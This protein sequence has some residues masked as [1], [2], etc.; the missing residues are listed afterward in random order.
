M[1]TV[2]LRKQRLTIEELFQA[3]DLEAV[4][5]VTGDGQEYFLEAAGEFDQEVAELGR[6][7]KF[8][9]F[10]SERRQAG[11]RIPLAEVEKQLKSLSE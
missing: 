3:A 6:S 2:D 4:L 9:R 5:I 11:G 8:M 1:I 10:L 7:E